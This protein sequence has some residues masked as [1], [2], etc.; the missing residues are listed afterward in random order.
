MS[1]NNNDEVPTS[2]FT[3]INAT[4]QTRDTGEKC[5]VCG[6]HIVLV[7]Y[8]EF[9]TGFTRDT[10]ACDYGAPKCSNCGGIFHKHCGQCGNYH[11]PP[12]CNKCNKEMSQKCMCDECAPK[13]ILHKK[14]QIAK[15][16]E[17]RRQMIEMNELHFR[18]ERVK[19]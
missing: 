12:F 14:T 9:K 5:V 18:G 1:S 10:M 17:E 15:D 7:T 11:A 19:G 3:D 2:A 16:E 8:V 13:H 6:K 4:I